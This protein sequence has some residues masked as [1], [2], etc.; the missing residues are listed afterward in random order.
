MLDSNPEASKN[1]RQASETGKMATSLL[2]SRA[3]LRQRTACPNPRDGPAFTA[4]PNRKVPE[5]RLVELCTGPFHGFAP[6]LEDGHDLVLQHVAD[7]DPEA[8]FLGRNQLTN[9]AFEVC[10]F[11]R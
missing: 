2:S 5:G 9:G 4:R 3:I 7:G 10:E 11:T 8:F 6:G 1:R